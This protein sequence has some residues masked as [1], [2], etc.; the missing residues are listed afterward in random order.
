MFREFIE[1]MEGEGRV[2]RIGQELSP[3]EE[4]SF[5]M[6][7]NEGRI[8]VFES[9]KGYGHCSVVSGTASS[10]EL[11][12][13]ALGTERDKILFRILR[14]MEN[15]KEYKVKESAEFLENEVENP[16]V[17]KHIPLL[18]YFFKNQ[19]FYTTS[20]IVVSKSPEGDLNYSFHRMKYLG[21]NRFAIR[22]VA[23][24]HLDTNFQRSFGD[25][26]VA[27]FLGVHPA[28]EIAVST[29]LP[30]GVN[31][32]L[33]ANALLD[34]KLACTRIEDFDI[35]SHAEIVMIGRIKKGE[36]AEEGPFIDLTETW[37]TVRKQPVVEI[38]KLYYREDF[39]YRTLLPGGNE[40]RLLMGLPQE[41]RMYRIISN[42]LPR[43]KNLCLTQGGCC[44]LHAVVS[45]EK[46]NEGEGKNVGL[47]ALAAHPSL[48]GVVVVDEDIDPANPEEVE[49]AIATRVQPEKDVIVISDCKGSSLDPSHDLKKGTTGKWI[50]DATA[51]AGEIEMF[52]KVMG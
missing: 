46:R 13:R 43:V 5:V 32:M 34:G 6:R 15:L 2:V 30:Y 26:K 12:A 50:I 16:E 49:W 29:S 18:K 24:R 40:H 19:P 45:I 38:E 48:K 9:P 1:K 23:G 36:L 47:A 17:I 41:P 14:A 28:V 31:E 27:I 39:L 22:M 8:C 20:T 4:M 42:T 44:W 35:P 25:L 3:A 10:R 33:L 11:I 51:P 21:K 52:R 37:D 7:E